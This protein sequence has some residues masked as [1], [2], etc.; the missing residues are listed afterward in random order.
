MTSGPRIL[1]LLALGCAACLTLSS[2]SSFGPL[3][4]HRP[5][6]VATSGIPAAPPSISHS[7]QA[8]GHEILQRSLESLADA[9][10]V[11]VSTAG[12][13]DG[14][15]FEYTVSGDYE[16]VGIQAYEMRQ[17]LGHVS[18]LADS[19]TNSYFIKANKQHGQLIS[20][21]NNEDFL[22]AL[23]EDHWLLLP[24]SEEAAMILVSDEIDDL[25]DFLEEAIDT[26]MLDYL[27]VESFEG[28]SAHRFNS[29]NA[30]LW[31][32]ADD[33]ALPLRLQSVGF[34]PYLIMASSYQ[35]WNQENF[36]QL[37]DDDQ[38]I[39]L[40]EDPSFAT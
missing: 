14:V 6:K 28:T 29:A 5:A 21:T 25:T 24:E 7:L 22:N 17:G 12:S 1:S 9:Y 32:T 35:A 26:S 30:T 39:M 36:L 8:R 10:E 37:P 34:D 19:S 38:V 40:E 13:L 18:W 20:P 16:E 3:V 11:R 15:A 4:P 23:S 31:L 27:G 33:S 2:C